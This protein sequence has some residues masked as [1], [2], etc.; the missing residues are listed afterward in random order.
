[1]ATHRRTFYK[2]ASFHTSDWWIP[3]SDGHSTI[4]ATEWN[5]STM[6]PSSGAESKYETLS[7][8]ATLDQ[9][10]GVSRT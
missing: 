6:L 4:R 1:M 5:G 8:D 7:S 3:R 2:Y 10:A 9:L